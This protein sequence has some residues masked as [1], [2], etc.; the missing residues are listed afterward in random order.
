M[1]YFQLINAVD[2]FIIYDDVNFIKQGWINKNRILVNNTAHVFTVPVKNTSSFVQIH[3]TFVDDKMYDYWKK[4]F[5]RTLEQA[6][7]KA[8]Y[9]EIV[10]KCITTVFDNNPTSIKEL[11][12]SSIE[13]VCHYLDIKTEIVPTSSTYNN[14]LLKAESRIIDLCKKE[15]AQVYINAAGGME[16]YSRDNFLKEG[17]QLYF[18]K[19]GEIN[20]HQ[21][22]KEFV[23][24]LS[25]I[26]VMMFNSSA[27][28]SSMLNDFELINA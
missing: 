27:E 15:N 6:Y 28:I 25:I 26:D 18:L 22:N 8:P 5:F 10:I 7:T 9:F 13:F 20:Y 14:Q 1:G 2:K 21:F 24:F 4:K 19:S 11:A 23:P 12:L 16:L 3:N 17:I